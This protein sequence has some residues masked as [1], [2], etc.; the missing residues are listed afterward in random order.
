[1]TSLDTLGQGLQAAGYAD[2]ATQVTALRTPFAA[3]K[4]S[5]DD[6]SIRAP[7]V[8]R[9]YTELIDRSVLPLFDELTLKSGLTSTDSASARSLAT[10]TT[11]QLPQNVVIADT[12]LSAFYP[13]IAGLGQ[14]GA[15]I[16]NATRTEAT[17][18]Y[19]FALN[20]FTPSLIHI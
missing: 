11:A 10:L 12:A 14:K 19:Q 1:M 6:L 18:R 15:L 7:A 17:V 2:L 4:Q 20:A 16:T 9:S 8:Q 13:I 5:I 3:Q